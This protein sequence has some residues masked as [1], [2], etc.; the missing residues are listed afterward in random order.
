MRKK[1]LSIFLYALIIIGCGIYFYYEIHKRDNFINDLLN[2]LKENS[3]KLIGLE[4]FNQNRNYEIEYNGKYYSDSCKVISITGEKCFL[5]DLI[6]GNKL[7]LRYS[8]LNCNTCIDEQID[9]SF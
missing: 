4:T 9:I 1:Q 3:Y 7:V 8:E 5:T 6:R 2:E